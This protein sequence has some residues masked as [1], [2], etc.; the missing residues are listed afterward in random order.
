MKNS[1]RLILAGIALGLA[2]CS[3]TPSSNVK[4]SGI[5]ATLSVT[6]QG[7]SALC[8]AVFQVGG[9]TG[10]YLSLDNGDTVTCNGIAM[11]S[12]NTL[13]AILYSATLPA[14]AGATYAVV[15]NRTGEDPHISLVTLP[16]PLAFT[17]GRIQERLTAK[18]CRYPSH[19]PKGLRARIM[20][21]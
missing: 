18:A 15:L 10:T 19:G 21:P 1:K 16:D 6:A 9:S 14:N 5:Y 11:T 17:T 7:G 2:A 3:N 8:T 12:S 20:S 13:G 4:T